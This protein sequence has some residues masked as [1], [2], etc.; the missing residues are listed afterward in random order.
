MDWVIPFEFEKST[1]FFCI[2]IFCV[3]RF[4]I[5]Q[6]VGNRFL[7]FFWNHN[8][9]HSFTDS[10]NYF[11]ILCFRFHLV[12]F[13]WLEFWHFFISNPLSRTGMYVFRTQPWAPSTKLCPFDFF[14]LHSI[15]NIF[16]LHIY[17]ASQIKLWNWHIFKYT[18]ITWSPFPG[19]FFDI[20]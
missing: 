15:S 11:L 9:A 12:N 16:V 13:D 6:C 10:D 2:R 17:L 14:L 1:T 20:D 3:S 18:Y 4:Q 19:R 8:L 7:I 5:E